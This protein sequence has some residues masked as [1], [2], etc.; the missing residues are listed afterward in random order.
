MNIESMI[1]A[2]K[3]GRRSGKSRLIGFSFDRL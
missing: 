2:D 3:L 1:S